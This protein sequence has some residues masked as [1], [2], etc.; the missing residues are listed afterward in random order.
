MASSRS[1]TSPSGSLA[2]DLSDRTSTPAVA[3]TAY[4]PRESSLGF[5]SSTSCGSSGA[6]RVA[7]VPT[8]CPAAACSRG[9]ARSEDHEKV[10]FSQ[11]SRYAAIPLIEIIRGWSGLARGCAAR[12]SSRSQVLTR[13]T[14]SGGT[15]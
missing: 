10:M 7:F 1:P 2:P 9:R 13:S 4:P 5:P 8:R 6:M 11:A 15:T 12:Y 3:T 14:S